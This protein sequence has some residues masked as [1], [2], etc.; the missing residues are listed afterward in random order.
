MAGPSAGDSQ[1]FEMAHKSLMYHALS[2]PA[3][4]GSQTMSSRG[5]GINRSAEQSSSGA[6]CWRG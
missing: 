3:G 2:K 5:R 6:A 1:V 4:D